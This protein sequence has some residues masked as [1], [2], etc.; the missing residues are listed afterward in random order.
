M[1]GVGFWPSFA[2]YKKEGNNSWP[3]LLGVFESD[4]QLP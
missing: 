1:T 2:V 3:P 4:L